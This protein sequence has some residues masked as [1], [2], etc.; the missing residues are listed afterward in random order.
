[1]IPH[2]ATGYSPRKGGGFRVDMSDFE[3]L[4]DGGVQTTVEDLLRWDANF[5]SHTVGG[6]A[7]QTFLHETGKLTNGKTIAY[8]RG[9]FVGTFRGLRRVSHGGA[10]AGY[11]AELMRFPEQKTSIVCLSNLASM[12]PTDLCEG[13]AAIVL[14]DQLEPRR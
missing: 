5:Y 9:L 13:V 12:S 14:K 10:W 2:R 7:L 8:A 6:D 11:R 3:Q 4:G 1:V